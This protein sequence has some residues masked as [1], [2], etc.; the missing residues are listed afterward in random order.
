MKLML[1]SSFF[2]TERPSG[3]TAAVQALADGLLQRGVQV[4]VLATQ[5]QRETTQQEVRGV[6]IYRFRPLNWFWIGEKHRQPT[7]KRAVWQLFDI[8]NAHTW[9]IAR[10]VLERERPDV[11]HVHKLR[12]LSPAIWKAATDLGIPVVQTCHDYELWSPVGTLSGR[13]GSWAQQG[14]WFL[15]PYAWLRARMSCAVAAAVAPTRFVLEQHL[16]RGFFPRAVARAIPD[17]H[18]LTREEV[19]RRRKGPCPTGP[20]EEEVRLLFLGRLQAI[21]GVELLCE[22][23]VRSAAAWP[24]LHLD[25][26]GWGPLEP[27]LR[28]RY[29]GHPCITFHGPVLGQE[30]DRLIA[31][32]DAL[33]V[34]SIWPEVFGM[35]CAE[36]YTL[37]KPVIA[38]RVGGLPEVVEEGKTGWLV[39]PG[40]VDALVDALGRAAREPSRLRRMSGA[41]WDAAERLALEPV[42]SQHLA[43]YEELLDR[44]T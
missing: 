17:S 8:W 3:A 39:P 33:V 16:C 27:S 34:P 6:T 5:A 9:V 23:F 18:G 43:L 4:V 31:Q 20:S 21:K 30:R 36:A 19:Q 42:V 1:V 25:V 7:W 24:G 26:A 12:G 14:V 37:G 22:A 10:Q 29:G 2:G 40:D 15:R 38:T 41:C 35:V 13:V 11:V 28:E 44:G 32:S